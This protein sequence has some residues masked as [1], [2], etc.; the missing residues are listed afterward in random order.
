MFLPSRQVTE[1][2]VF[3][4]TK[5]HL[6]IAL[7]YIHDVVD[8]EDKETPQVPAP[9]NPLRITSTLTPLTPAAWYR[10]GVAPGE[11]KPSPMWAVIDPSAAPAMVPAQVTA[12]P[13]VPGP[14]PGPYYAPQPAPAAPAPVGAA[15]GMAVAPGGAFAPQAVAPVQQ[16]PV[17]SR[18]QL[19]EDL[20][21]LKELYEEKLITEEEYNAKKKQVLDRLQ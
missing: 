8:V 4:D 19:K 13:G 6:N 9:R 2:I 11:D 18:E 20:R 16:Q 10:I 21:L 1:G 15:P 14:Y 17:A 5:Q 3:V 12:Q 7:T